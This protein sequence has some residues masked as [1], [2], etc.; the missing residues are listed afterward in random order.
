MIETSDDLGDFVAYLED[1]L[2]WEFNVDSFEDRL[3]LQKYL[4]LGEIF[5]L[6]HSYDYNLYNYGPYSPKLADDYYNLST[7]ADAS[8]APDFDDTEFSDFVEGK[9]AKWLEVAATTYRFMKKYDSYYDAE[10][11]RENVVHRVCEVKDTTPGLVRSTFDELTSVV[12]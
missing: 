2:N 3:K 6:N 10:E 1:E 8:R 12:P 4:Y 7:K 5:D 11:Y 9:D